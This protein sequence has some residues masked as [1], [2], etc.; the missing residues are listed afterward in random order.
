MKLRKNYVRRVLRGGS[1][2]YVAPW[3]LRCTFRYAYP[4]EFRFRNFGFRVVIRRK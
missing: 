4:P 2:D 3:D 1:I